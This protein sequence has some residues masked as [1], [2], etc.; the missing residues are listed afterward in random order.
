MKIAICN[1]IRQ[2]NENRL[3][4]YNWARQFPGSAWITSL[5]ERQAELDIDIASG[6]VA[7][8]NVKSGRW[9]AG[10]VRVVQELDARHGQEL[11][12]LGA[13]PSVLTIFE[14]PLVAY[15]SIDHLV[16][17]RISFPHCVGPRSL[18][19]LMPAQR[20]AS[21]WPL[22]FPTHWLNQVVTPIP[23]FQRKHAV[24]VAA[25]KYWNERRWQRVRS[26]K[27]ALRIIRHGIRKRL[28]ATYRECRHMQLHDSRLALID[29]LA[30]RNQIDVFGSG[31]D[32]LDNLPHEWAKRLSGS[33]Q[34]F[35]GQ[36]SDKV[37]LSSHYRFTITFENTAYPGYVTEKL[38]D[39]LIA[40]T[41]PVYLG[42]PDITAQVPDAA[43]IDTR[44]LG[45]RE[46]IIERMQQLTESEALT[47]ISAG[48]AFLKSPHGQ[49]H[50]HEGFGDWVVSL[51]RG[52][53]VA[54]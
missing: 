35:H 24:L 1:D 52:K 53:G 6:D 44:V 10:D 40:G 43:F 15:R 31:W 13:V 38:I 46:A 51:L 47:I 30:S 12:R 7:L 22:T 29:S 5:F 37:V 48:R 39:G 11:C 33:R 23:W 2:F 3:K 25:N 16:R 18:F 27:D 17:L 20:Q 14:S 45:S 19:E 50:S 28:S 21:Y 41:V 9:L 34:I 36:C 42:A 4:D 8:Q 54:T 32:S 26:T 49:R